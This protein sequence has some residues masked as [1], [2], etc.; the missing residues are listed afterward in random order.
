MF[1][2]PLSAP[3]PCTA[4]FPH[5]LQW[6]GCPPVPKPILESQ[7]LQFFSWLPRIP[8]RALGWRAPEPLQNVLNPSRLQFDCSEAIEGSSNF[9][10]S[11]PSEVL[12]N[13]PSAIREKREEAGLLM[14]MKLTFL[15]IFIPR[16]I[17]LNFISQYVGNIVS[18]P[19]NPV[20]PADGLYPSLLVQINLL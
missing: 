20:E 5:E 9:H 6:S 14:A 15:P 2:P 7:L 16:Q 4:T 10:F 8:I 3:H 12:R 18:F 17:L 13:F 1:L 11:L 19:S